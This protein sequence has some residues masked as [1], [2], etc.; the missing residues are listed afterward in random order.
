MSDSPD[1]LKRRV[2]ELERDNRRLSEQLKQLVKAERDLY[3][4]QEQFDSQIRIY[5][6]LSDIGRRFNSTFDR[7]EILRLATNFVL[8]VLNFERCLVFLLRGDPPAYGFS[9]MDGYY[10]QSERRRFARVSLALND[11]VLI[12]LKEGREH[13]LCPLESEDE[14]LAPLRETFMMDE[15]VIFPLG[16]D[17]QTPLGLVVAGN[18]RD[19]AP[20]QARVRPE[21]DAI[22]GLA[23]LVSQAST[24]VNNARFY[25][26]LEMERKQLEEKVR[27]L[28]KTEQE[29]FRFQEELDGQM[30]I[31]RNLYEVGK[32]FNA[33]FELLEILD[34]A[35]HFVIYQLSFERCIFL[36]RPDDGSE[37]LPVTQ[38]GFYDDDVL[39]K[40][41][42]LRLD[43]GDPSLRNLLAGDEFLLCAEGDA[44][45]ISLPLKELFQMDEFVV[46]RI[47]GSIE[48][49]TGLLVAGNSSAMQP[50]QSRVRRD[51]RALLGLA[52]L[53]SQASTAIKNSRFYEELEAER[54]MLEENVRERTREL[55]EATQVAE[56]A[57]RA[58][59]AFLANMSHELR[60]PL[61]AV[62]GY[63]EMLQEE[64]AELQND[65]MMGDL[66]KINSAGKHLLAL[67]NDVLDL[68][69]IEAGKM[70]MYIETF[71]V[72]TMIRDITVVAQPLAA[73]NGNALDVDCPDSVG[74]IK[75]DIT[76]LRQSLINLLSNSCKFTKGGTVSL[77]VRREGDWIRFTVTD[78]GIGI[79]PEQQ[80]RLFQAFS[81][82]DASTTR[83]FGGTGLGLAL[84]RRLCQLMGGDITVQSEV[85]QGAEFEIRIP[86]QSGN[87]DDEPA[88]E[89]GEEARARVLVVDDDAETRQSIA[90]LLSDAGYACDTA[91][92]GEDALRRAR[93][94]AP[95]LM[96]LDVLMPDMDGWTVLKALKADPSLAE[97]PVVLVSVARGADLA[98]TLGAAEF[99]TKPL[100]DG[101]LENVVSRI[102][103]DPQRAQVLVVEDDEVTRNLWV[104]AL[105]KSGCSVEEAANGELALQALER[106]RP[107]CVLLDLMM[108]EMD[109]FE[110]VEAMRGREEWATIPIV[111]ATAKD[112]DGEELHRLSEDVERII[113]KGTTPRAG[114]VRAV[115]T[116]LEQRGTVSA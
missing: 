44:D 77:V 76:K 9:A 64:A 27:Q 88:S 6:H 56:S 114:I 97:V 1:A 22:L 84:T 57:N 74:A 10:E 34:I 113:Q 115:R 108:P 16:G 81:Q 21:G 101:E 71:D 25:W 82:A 30:G 40:V 2:E 50:Y 78:T 35:V 99:L 45:P 14:K 90:Q 100:E 8:Y 80:G 26:D 32:R 13:V 104:R 70:E 54:Q 98:Y 79:S 39:Q 24:A 46:F 17:Q 48:R 93:A 7:A 112:L 49:P 91:A 86:I 29:L 20:Y 5:Q 106:S 36:L 83:K 55:S 41:E 12:P 72:G 89:A 11:P 4:F 107:D 43:L 15:F 42:N 38:D 102:L 85:G 58:K 51:N 69:K 3:E 31:Y 33:T 37:F 95:D 60:T 68:S 28:V 66:T 73:K 47:G 96:T 116:L 103:S 52:N 109:G 62:I 65:D 18:T 111:V 19:S 53:V 94:H 67:I 63:S 75:S 92:T 110:V 105:R 59:S 61:N 23:N 87:T